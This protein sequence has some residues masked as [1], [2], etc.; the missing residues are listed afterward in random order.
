MYYYL[1]RISPLGRKNVCFAGFLIVIFFS[2][3][4]SL[5]AKDQEIPEFQDRLDLA[6]TF[7][8][9]IDPDSARII[10]QDLLED[11]E[12]EGLEYSPL[13]LEAEVHLARLELKFSND[14][15]SRNLVSIIQRATELQ[16]WEVVAHAH[17]N[18]ALALE[19]IQQAKT[20]DEHL[21]KA[22]DL[23]KK[24]ELRGLYPLYAIRRSSH[25]RVFQI[26]SDSALFYAR[27]ALRTSGE[28]PTYTKAA[29]EYLLAQ[30]WKDGTFEER[31]EQLKIAAGIYA[32]IG[33]I[34][35]EIAMYRNV[36][37]W[38]T[39]AKMYDSAIVYYDQAILALEGYKKPYRFDFYDTMSSIYEI[40]AELFRTLGQSDSAYQYLKLSQESQLIYRNYYNA[41][42]VAEIEARFNDENKVRQIEQQAWEI[43]L[44][45]SRSNI[46]FFALLLVLLATLLIGRLYLQ[47]RDANKKNREQALRLSQ[48]DEV[49]SRF[50]ANI[51]H[52]LRTP[53]TLMLSPI[54][55]VLKTD[56]LDNQQEKLLKMA[57]RAGGQLNGLI[58]QILTLRQ[59][60]LDELEIETRQ[61]PLDEWLRM[62]LVQFESLALAKNID[63]TYRNSLPEDSWV[64]LDREKFRQVLYNLLSNAFKYS[65]E[66]GRVAVES[67]LKENVLR[68]KLSDNGPGIHEEDIPRIFDRYFQTT[69]MDKP[70]EGGTGIGLALCKEYIELFGGEIEVESKIGEGSSFFISIPLDSISLEDLSEETLSESILTT[71]LLPVSKPEESLVDTGEGNASILIVEDNPELS[72]YLKT[73]LSSEY[74]LVVMENGAKAWEFLNEEGNSCDLILSDLMMPV[75]DGFQLLERLKTHEFSRGIPVLML[76]ARAEGKDRLKALRIGVDDYMVKPFEEEELK[77]RVS[78]LLKNLSTRKEFEQKGSEEK[79]ESR[80]IAREDRNWLEGFEAY[81]GEH[82]SDSRMT[83]PSLAIHFSMSE[84]TLLRQSKRLI[85]LTPSQYIQQMRLEHAR[86]LLENRAFKAISQVAYEAGYA[87]TRS[88]S[89]AFKR[90]YGKLPSDYVNV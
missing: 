53:L 83:V 38:Y 47:I 34:A 27:E 18:L 55:S 84:S 76:T 37:L 26:N 75:M 77:I 7:K 68:M 71:E 23:I 66:G 79:E 78:N 39:N 10:F 67:E 14:L 56:S 85:G 13:Y 42:T 9:Q 25:F 57:D 62:N 44:E 59:L 74:K 30:L 5:I 58:N 24:H 36:I 69:Q 52:E 16:E 29:A 54:Q 35:A 19:L 89:R 22:R 20:S 64:W 86:K 49:K 90:R 48:L 65:V 63:Y 17:I 87:D 73:I 28:E 6:I 88:F 31:I 43:K 60:D 80:V 33:D 1:H 72:E 12:K 2:F 81:V 70:I 32:K 61:T 11:L 46:A 3:S 8:N 41:Q 21:D 4:G 40:R 82:L 15:A 45:R 51:S 50:F